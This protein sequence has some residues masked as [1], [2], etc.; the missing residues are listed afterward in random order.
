MASKSILRAAAG[1]FSD[2]HSDVDYF[3]SYELVTHPGLGRD[4]F[5]P[6]RHSVRPEAVDFVMQ[7]FFE[8]L[9]LPAEPAPNPPPALAENP[10]TFD[11]QDADDLICEDM[12]LEHFNA[13]RD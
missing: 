11:V 8:G 5:A 10:A 7:H 13:D 12:E 3:P 6:D 1:A 9:G 2:Q 4:M